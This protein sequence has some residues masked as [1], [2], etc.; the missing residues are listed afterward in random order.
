MQTSLEDVDAGV[1]L[2]NVRRHPTAET[3]KAYLASNILSIVLWGIHPQIQPT[4]APKP[5]LARWRHH[6]IP[7]REKNAN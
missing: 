5:S 2:G 3:F 1:P 7:R 4:T 6:A